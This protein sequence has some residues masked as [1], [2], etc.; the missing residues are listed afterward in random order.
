M[1]NKVRLVCGS[2][3]VGWAEENKWGKIGTTV[4]EQQCNIFLKN[5]IIPKI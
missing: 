2:R 1:D 5:K 3:R 4:K